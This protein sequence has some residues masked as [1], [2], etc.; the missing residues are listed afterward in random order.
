[1]FDHRGNSDTKHR[2]ALLNHVLCL[3]EGRTIDC[4]LG[5]REFI[6]EDWFKYLCDKHIPFCIRVKHSTLI[7]KEGRP[8]VPIK[9]H[10]LHLKPGEKKDITAMIHGVPVQLTVMRLSDYSLL[11][12]ASTVSIAIE[13]LALYAQRW[14][15]ECFFKSLKTNGFNLEDTHMKHHERLILLFGC[16]GIAC[17]WSIKMGV[18]K[19]DIK[20]ILLKNHQRKTFS[21]FSYGRRT[22]QS[23]LAKAK[24]SSL[25][26]EFFECLINKFKIPPRLVNLA[27]VY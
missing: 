16:C 18:I 22:L 3:L 24:P 26:Q 13:T 27:V 19:H 11:A 5:D 4:L 7:P 6:G 15:I 1:L 8:P 20:P 14:T 10:Y 23:I 2:I 9:Q 21:L 25:W 12:V 17:A